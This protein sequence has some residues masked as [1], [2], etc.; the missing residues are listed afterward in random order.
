MASIINMREN[1]Y[2]AIASELAKM[3]AEQLESI[4]AVIS[5][6]RE[7]VTSE[8]AF[9]AEQTT[10]KML[11]MLDAFSSEI[12]SLLKQVFRDSEAGTSNMIESMMITDSI[13][14]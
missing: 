11:D 3:H 13:R 10:E 6:M 7:L 14:G 2:Q 9:Y 5:E 8:D 12:I 1:E 4:N